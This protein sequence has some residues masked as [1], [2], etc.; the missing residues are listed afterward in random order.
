MIVKHGNPGG[1]QDVVQMEERV[2]RRW[3]SRVTLQDVADASD[4]SVAT[5][6]R[7]LSGNPAITEATAIRVREAMSALGYE[8]NV[9][10]RALRT[11]KTLTIG[12]VVPD[13]AN[14]F[15]AEITKVAQRVSAEAGYNLI[16]CD[17]DYS[18]EQE[19]R[20]L[21]N[22]ARRHVDGVLFMAT[23]NPGTA[24]KLL[25]ER[26]VPF[27]LMDTELEPYSRINAVLTDP[28]RGVY[29]AT[30]YLLDLGHRAIA[31]IAAPLE[32]LPNPRMLVAYQRAMEEA[33]VHRDDLLVHAAVTVEGAHAVS[34][35]LL[36]GPRP[37][38]IVAYADLMA[39]GAYQAAQERGLRIPTDLSVLGFDDTV[40]APFLN[41]KL[42]TV[43]TDKGGIGREA[44]ALLLNQIK[45]GRPSRHIVTLPPR[46]VIRDSCAPPPDAR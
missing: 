25:T 38:A 12:L 29:E 45:E 31:F 6:S 3:N 9:L 35:V 41:P 36:D 33:D 21:L 16:L 23:G 1:G 4:V 26:Q 17:S 32:L 24:I 43:A 11:N 10:A 13:I 40:I 19:E 14:P 20:L 46:L 7:V 44:V 15:Y 5:V 2:S 28:D 34:G 37:T 39:M 42:T 30:R 18:H 8:P 27:V 22:L